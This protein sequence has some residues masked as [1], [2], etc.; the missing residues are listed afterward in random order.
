MTDNSWVLSGVDAETRRRVAAAAKHRGQCVGDFLSEVLTPPPSSA[1]EP[2]SAPRAIENFAYR[3]RLEALERRLGVALGGLEGAVREL[4]G[5]VATLGARVNDTEMVAADAAET[6]RVAA[7][8]LGANFANLRKRLA[9]A[10]EDASTHA[11]ASECIQAD[12]AAQISRLD[13]Q[14]DFI[15]DIARGAR[16]NSVVLGEAQEALKHAV[17]ED[18][19]AL[20][21]DTAA[22]LD[23]GL[24]AIRAD[25]E[26][27]AARADAALQ[28]LV[29]DFRSFRESIEGQIGDSQA[30][31]RGRM[32]AAFADVARRMEALAERVCDNEHA[33]ARADQDLRAEL[34]K[35]QGATKGLVAETAAELRRTDASLH[36]EFARALADQRKTLEAAQ[37]K[38]A[39]EIA[40]LQERQRA[41]T[42]HLGLLESAQHNTADEFEEFR[43]NGEAG[44]AE[45]A[46]QLGEARRE[47]SNDVARV[48]A[49][50][51]AALEK[52]AADIS[53]GDEAMAR[54]AERAQRQAS[55][56]YKRLEGEVAELRGQ[57]S[58][59]SARLHLLD[60]LLGMQALA[61]GSM[62]PVAER[63]SDLEREHADQSLQLKQ[64]LERTEDEPALAAL[65]KDFAALARQLGDQHAP[66]AQGV[67]DL[68]NR[69]EALQ[70]MQDGDAERLHAMA[71]VLSR[72]VAQGLDSASHAEDRLDRLEAGVARLEEISAAPADADN[73]PL[74]GVIDRLAELETRQATA[75]ET[76]RADI[77]R[78]VDDN[79]R[80]L[81]ALEAEDRAAPLLESI[82]AVLEHRLAAIEAPDYAAEF[83]TLRQRIESR[84]HDIEGRNVRAL[85]Q[86]GETIALLEQRFARR[87][88]DKVASSA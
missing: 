88:D 29:Q 80:R 82:A 45:T 6:A 74:P 5:S 18:F 10:E 55:E 50:T 15:E 57:Q 81:A 44:A 63:L 25:A 76:L 7:Q 65:R 17:A 51:L 85:E 40:D 72:V 34:A 70:D 9:V 46:R 28:A 39:A 67:L 16:Q 58:G 24:D 73:P 8:D 36:H 3:H 48:E 35:M 66:L 41:A 77:A 59:A 64:V 1:H 21:L 2:R 53:V 61:T 49:C 14:I 19:G 20:A 83:D 38:L 79:E 71:R 42:A 23:G 56:A 62:A 33:Y 78:F 32:Q 52:L 69:L 43:R 84:I 30:E 54:E 75:F 12:F 37:T 60:R 47:F 31:T 87:G 86:V 4:D 13:H 22:R 26:I 27:A 11:R 68:C